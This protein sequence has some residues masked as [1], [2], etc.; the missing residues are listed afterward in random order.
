MKMDY[1]LQPLCPTSPSFPH[2][3]S[4]NPGGI[5]TGP[6]IKTFGG[7]GLGGRISS[8]P[9]AIFE[10]V[11]EAHEE[12]D[13]RRIFLSI[14]ASTMLSNFLGLRQLLKDDLVVSDIARTKH[15]KF[16]KIFSIFSAVF[17]FFAR[18]FFFVIFV[19]VVVRSTFLLIWRI[20]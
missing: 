12:M 3:F 14:L 1:V 13:E 7:D 18:K 6:P 20:F 16:R 8:N 4:G 15:A 17:A 2:V 11:H 10:G 9:A 5:R 19:S